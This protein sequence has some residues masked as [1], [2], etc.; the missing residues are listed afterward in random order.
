MQLSPLVPYAQGKRQGEESEEAPCHL[1]RDSA[2]RLAE[3]RKDLIRPVTR[4]RRRASLLLRPM[5]APRRWT[6]NR[7][8]L[9][10]GRLSSGAGRGGGGSLDGFIRGSRGQSGAPTQH[11]PQ[12]HTVHGSSLREAVLPSRVLPASD[13]YCSATTQDGKMEMTDEKV[14]LGGWRCVRGSSRISGLAE[15]NSARFCVG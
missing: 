4:C 1:Q 15:K 6:Q 7:C 3:R 2:R 10:H 11:P 9:H 8:L 5:L 14:H 13:H 12:S